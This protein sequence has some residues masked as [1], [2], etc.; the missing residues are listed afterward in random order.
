LKKEDFRLFDDR[1]EVEIAAFH[2][3]AQYDTRPV[4]LW[5]AVLCNEGG[6]EGGS[7]EFK[8]REALFRPALDRLDKRDTVGVAHWCDNG[9]ASLDLLPTED[10][11]GPIS[12]LVE[13]LKP[14]NF[15]I[16]GNSNLVGEEAFR[17][18][19]RLIIRDAQRR[20][21]EP[22][23]AIVFL[24]GGRG[25]QPSDELNQLVDDVLEASGIVFGIR[26]ELSSTE[27]PAPAGRQG[28]LVHYL[29]EETGGQ[30]L[31]APPKGYATALEMI[32]VQLHF[33]YELGFVPP[34]IDGKRHELKVELTKEAQE[35]YKGVRLGFRPEYIPVHEV[36][37][38]AR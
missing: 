14:K 35:R 11:D 34:K 6:K 1:Q 17:K 15:G 7:N 27:S 3:G 9:E 10:R 24:Y 18:M 5:L 22:L 26:D 16:G 28:H 30:Y 12:E 36:P 37:A 8:G 20:N 29:A 19:I 23:P 32:L 4:V 21:P 2:A 33:R 31:S 25:A 13:I 38:W